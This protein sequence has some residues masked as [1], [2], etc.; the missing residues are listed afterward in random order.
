LKLTE[1]KILKITCPPGKK[2]ILVSDDE[3][4]GLYIRVSASAIEG[5]EGGRSYLAQYSY[6]GRKR[7]VPL[8]DLT[9]ALARSEAVKI[10]GAVASGLDPAGARKAAKAMAKSKAAHVALT[11]AGLL[12]QWVK[13]GLAGKR[14]GAEAVRAIKVAFPK[15]LE[16]PAADLTRD[17]AVM[18]L[19]E[20]TAAGSPQMAARTMAYSRACFSWAMKRG[21]LTSNP[22]V[23]L[24]LAKITRRE[25]V[26]ADEELTAVWQATAG[27]GSFNNIV[28]MLVLTGQ[29]EGEVAGMAWSELS[30]DLSAWT[31]P[32]SRTKNGVAS[33]VPLS[34]QAQAIIK[35]AKRYQGNRLVFPGRD[36]A[37]NGWARAKARLDKISG[38]SG[39]RLH[40]LRRSVATNLQKLG[41]RLEVTESV[42][43]HISGS[44]SG[45]VGIYQR[46]DWADEKKAALAAWAGR[47]EAIV[48]G[49]EAGANVIA[50][51][52]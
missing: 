22:F 45:I 21:K 15:H 48:T 25:R 35:D 17:D 5:K 28:R 34:A 9:L 49:I 31:L 18:V 52:A 11:L 32:G 51:R 14:Y 33:I 26:L 30:D 40:D 47:V 24:P 4:R 42:L 39:W 19:D 10:M 8:G 44:R 27:P 2:D 7:R 29:R 41:V 37:F 50:L 23:N 20:M 1:I 38:V 16:L 12:D 36:G 6:A 13:L 46:H 3:L 43:N